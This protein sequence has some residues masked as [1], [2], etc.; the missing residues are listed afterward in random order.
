MNANPPTQPAE[1]ASRTP[2]DRAR[3][4][5]TVTLLGLLIFLIGAKPEWLGMDRSPVIGFAQICVF[6]IG[7]LVIC[8]GGYIGLSSMWAGQEK[9]IAA[10]IGLRLVATG[11]VIA[12]F[13]ALADVFGMSLRD[14]P[15]VP[16]FGP[17]QQAGVEIGMIVI[18]V[19]MLMVI[20]FHRLS[21]R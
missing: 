17:W 4:S 1:T 6:M 21:K 12:I 14:D 15:R 19:G 20:P 10:D 7:L 3:F 13:S 5:I 11:Y 16:F 8:L 2:T 9:S 18:A